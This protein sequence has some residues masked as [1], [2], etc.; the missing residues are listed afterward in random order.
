M[1]VCNVTLPRLLQVP[2]FSIML[3]A[4]IFNN[5]KLKATGPYDFLS[6]TY[7]YLFVGIGA[8]KTKVNFVY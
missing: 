7:L 8:E 3:A 2:R 6:L 5:Y 1:N 4:N